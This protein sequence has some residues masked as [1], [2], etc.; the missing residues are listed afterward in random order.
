WRPRAPA[1]RFRSSARA[2]PAPTSSSA[3]SAGLGKST[4]RRAQPRVAS[5]RTPEPRSIPGRSQSPRSPTLPS[6]TFWTSDLLW[7][8]SDGRATD[9]RFVHHD[10]ADPTCG[11]GQA[12]REPSSSLRLVGCREPRQNAHRP[13]LVILL[14]LDVLEVEVERVPG[15]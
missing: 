6:P 1:A 3:E 14:D 11:D 13:R 4:V 7:S 9:D 12:H 10:R 8:G 2:G 5:R 15:D